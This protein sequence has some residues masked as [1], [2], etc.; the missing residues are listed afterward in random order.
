MYELGLKIFKEFVS[1]YDMSNERV[2]IKYYHTLRVVN[3]AEM[4]ASNLELSNREVELAKLIALFHDLGRFKQAKLINSFDDLKLD[5]SLL[6]VEIL[7]EEGLINKLDVTD[8]E[9]DI[10]KEAI[11]KHNDIY[12]DNVSDEALIQ[13]KIIRDADKLDNLVLALHIDKRTIFEYTLE[14]I[15]TKE[16]MESLKNKEL[17]K[18]Q[19]IKTQNDSLLITSAFVFDLN[20]DTSINYVKKHNLV[21]KILE[22]LNIDSKTR[23]ELEVIFNEYM[24]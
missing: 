11:L 12:L 22:K 5:H 9:K 23:S 24:L 8:N 7:F 15:I 2:N 16:V 20:F 1:N 14:P 21:N 19:D 13:A 3:Y 10:I 6:S 4:I 18:K 17:V